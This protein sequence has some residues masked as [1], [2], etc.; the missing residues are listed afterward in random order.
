MQLTERITGQF[1]DSARLQVDSAERLAP[2]IAAAAEL[3]VDALL[4]E[5]K[6]L[7]CGHGS[8]ALL[9][10]NFASHMLGRLALER[11]GL[12]AMALSVDPAVLSALASDSGHSEVY[13]RQVLALGQPGDLLLAV[14]I[15]ADAHSELAAIAAAHERGMRVIAL[16]GDDTLAELLHTNDIHMGVPH[17]S[18]ARM[19]ELGMLALNCLCDSIDCILLGVE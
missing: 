13:S 1:F 11:P 5:H 16:G 19:Q 7:C 14:I 2:A 18:P 4:S 12:A 8:G 6:V 9:A 3:A 10:Q 17:E 15:D